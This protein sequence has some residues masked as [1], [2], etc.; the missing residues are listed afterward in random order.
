MR[1]TVIIPL[2]NTEKYIEEAIQSLIKQTYPIDQI[3]V[4]DDGSTDQG[5]SI[6]KK[7]PEVELIQQKNQ[8]LKKTL[9]VGL[10][11]AKG[12]YIGFLD[13]DDRWSTNKLALQLEIL[14]KQADV[15][16]VFGNS[17]H[18]KMVAD[19]EKFIA[20]LKGKNLTCGLYR[21]SVF[22]KIGLFTD[23]EQLHNFL[24]FLD[25]VHA[26]SL[27]YIEINDVIY[28]RRIHE[29]NMGIVEKQRQRDQYLATLKASLDR[30]R[31]ETDFK[32]DIK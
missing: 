8:G 21:K 2:Y 19:K 9:N 18:F 29:T 22:D 10:M 20:I 24:E 12:E 14:N 30:R 31:A 26:Y 15:D 27:K 13:A 28:E 7:Y 25:R 6:V 17:L 4:I 16:L 3:I 23:Q 5:A 11:H 1:T 32:E